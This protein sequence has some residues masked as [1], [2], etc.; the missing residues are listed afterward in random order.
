MLTLREKFNAGCD[1]TGRWSVIALGASIP[2]STA[3]DNML[4]GLVILCWL[5]GGHWAGHF[6]DIRKNAVSIAALV[7]FGLLCAG[8]LYPAAH[9]DVLLKYIDLLLVP[10]FVCF[11]QTESTRRRALQ[12]FCFAAFASIIVSYLA[13][14]N[15]LEGFQ[16]LPRT[17]EN[18][19]GFK[20]SITH[21]IIVS[22]AAYIFAV[23]A[24]EEHSR[25]RRLVYIALSAIAVH[26]VIFMV[27][28]RTGYVAVAAMFVYLAMAR[29]GRRG[30]LQAGIALIL[31]FVAAYATSVTFHHRIDAAVS[32]AENWRNGD[33]SATSVGLRLEWYAMTLDIIRDRPLGGFGTGSFPEVYARAVEGSNLIATTNPHNEYLLMMVQLGVIGLIGLL[34]LF[35]QAWL[36]AAQLTPPRY[37]Y[38]ARGLVLTFAS[39]CLFNSLLIDHTE[40]LLFA[41]MTGLLFAAPRITQHGT[42]TGR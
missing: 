16:Y 34:Y 9:P 10:A 22:I 17:A 27:F 6:Q 32:E 36:T 3:L 23:M 5:L 25:K 33:T 28:G 1:S 31:V 38:L 20:N 2:V 14:F 12:L 37:R 21:S 41:W 4:M 40:G 7:L 30:L 39:G 11:F 24:V 26:N 13:H 42:E 15:L 35:W 19:T 8:T 29:F 18:P